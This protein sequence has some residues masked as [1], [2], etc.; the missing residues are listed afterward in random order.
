MTVADRSRRGEATQITSQRQGSQPRIIFSDKKQNFTNVT[1]IPLR[2][3]RFSFYVG[4]PSIFES[5]IPSKQH[6]LHADV[7]ILSYYYC[8]SSG[9]RCKV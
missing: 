3:A 7:I 5:F 2:V 1:C 9:S 6:A 4:I 8:S